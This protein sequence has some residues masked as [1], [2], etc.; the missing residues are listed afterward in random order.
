LK[1]NF[2]DAEDTQIYDY[3]DED[4]CIDNSSEYGFDACLKIINNFKS[5][6]LFANFYF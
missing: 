1:A 4:S 3:E 2:Q 5:V 6:C